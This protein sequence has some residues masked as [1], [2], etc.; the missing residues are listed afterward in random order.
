MVAQVLNDNHE[1]QLYFAERR[2]FVNCPLAIRTVSERRQG[3]ERVQENSMGSGKNLWPR[4]FTELEC[5]QASSR[6]RENRMVLLCLTP[7]TSHGMAI[8]SNY[9]NNNS[10]PNTSFVHPFIF[11]PAEMILS[12]HRHLFPPSKTVLRSRLPRFCITFL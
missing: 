7:S 6:Q 5:S 12:Y 11:H 8:S 4:M 3:S 9:W 1:F 10:L 2:R